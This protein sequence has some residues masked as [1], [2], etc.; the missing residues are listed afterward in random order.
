MET[1]P[2]WKK[3]TGVLIAIW[4]LVGLVSVW[5]DG[6]DCDN[7]IN[8]SLEECQPEEDSYTGWD[9]NGP[10]EPWDGGDFPAP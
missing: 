2:L 3:V 1:T 5:G 9:P 10:G 8:S 4:I 7:P 6:T